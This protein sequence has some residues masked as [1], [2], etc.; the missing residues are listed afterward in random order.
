MHHGRSNVEEWERLHALSPALS[1]FF[2]GVALL[3]GLG[4][5]GAGISM[6]WSTQNSKT[7][8]HT[9]GVISESEWR[10]RGRDDGIAHIVYRYS[11]AGQSYDGNN[12]LPGINEYTSSDEEAKVRQYRPGSSVTVFYDPSDPQNSC[13]EVGVLTRTPFI[14]LG[15]A[16]FFILSGGSFAWSLRSR[17]PIPHVGHGTEAPPVIEDYYFLPKDK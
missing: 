7:W 17:R 10:L 11:V 4:L 3:L 5:F 9:P 2:T 15:L 8:P 1:Y 14:M 12:I 16:I 13:L 6:L